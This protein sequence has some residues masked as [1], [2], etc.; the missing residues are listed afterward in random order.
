V[1]LVEGQPK[2]MKLKKITKKE[3]KKMTKNKKNINLEKEKKQGKPYK[4]FK[5]SLIFKSRIA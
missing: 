2:R 3:L 4:L 1:K 5:H